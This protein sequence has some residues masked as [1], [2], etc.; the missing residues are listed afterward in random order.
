MNEGQEIPS[1]RIVNELI[2]RAV[3]SGASDIHFEPLA[4]E[5]LVRLRVDGQLHE[6]Q[7]IDQS[8]AERVLNRIKVLAQLDIAEKRLPQD[9]KFV[10]ELPKEILDLRISTFPTI[11]GEKIVIRIL[12]RSSGQLELDQLG[13]DTA[14]KNRLLTIMRKTHGFFLVS[15]PT[16]SGKTTTLH[17][18]LATIASPTLNITTLEDPIE[19]YLEGINQ[20]QMHPGIGFTFA[21]GIRSLLRQDPDIIMVGEIRDEETA[22]IA[23]Q[24]A[25]TGHL[26]VSTIHT[27]DAPSTVMRLLEMRIEPFLLNTALS[28]ILAQR[29]VRQLCQQCKVLVEPSQVQKEYIIAHQLPIKQLYIA[30]GCVDCNEVGYKG[31]IGIFE[32][33]EISHELRSLL[34]SQPN[35]IALYQQALADG[36]ISLIHDG[37]EKVNRGLTSLDE[38]ITLIS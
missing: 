4:D 14:M 6:Y 26:V 25:L 13:F 17:A 3:F 23:L 20:S 1:V 11:Y 24:A 2:E 7:R 31:R 9:G 16:G 35:F 37:T 19:Y 29:L 21:R 15:G 34:T 27:G 22:K 12:K 8:Y 18:L 10:Y 5:L 30:E 38:L 32:L 28:A 36:M 33:L